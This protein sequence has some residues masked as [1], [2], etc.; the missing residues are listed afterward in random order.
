MKTND[1]LSAIDDARVVEAIR[2]AEARTSG[3]I[4]VFVTKK[5]LKGKDVLARAREEFVRLGRGRTAERNGVLIF[6]VPSDQEFAVI[7]DEGVHGK[8]GG[9]FWEAMACAMQCHFRAGRF[10]EGL[11]A[12]VQQAGGLLAEHFPRGD[13][14]RN[15][16]LDAVERD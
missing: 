14:D 1:L 2:A 16:L 3:E 15:E 13:D 9:E 12:G 4:R 5:R 6:V 10:T 8:C 11:V 7:G